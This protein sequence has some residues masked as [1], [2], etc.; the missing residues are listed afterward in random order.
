MKNIL[1]R[2]YKFLLPFNIRYFIWNYIQ[3]K[4]NEKIKINI[5]KYFSDDNPSTHNFIKEIEYLKKNKLSVLPYTEIHSVKNEIKIYSDNSNGLKYILFENKKI[6]FK[7]SMN[8]LEIKSYFNELLN[9]QHPNSPHRYL[10]NSFNINKS[11]IVADIGVAE[12]IFSISIID[13]V[14]FIYLFEPDPEW[15]EALAFTFAPWSSKIKIIPKFISDITSIDT[16]ALD[17]FFNEFNPVDFLKIDVDG[18][19]LKLLNGAKDLIKNSKKLKI[20]ICTYH[21]DNDAF[22]FSEIMKNNSFNISI[23]SGYMLFYFDKNFKPP[24]FRKGVLRASKSI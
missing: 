6:Y 24:Y 13:E 1:Y 20:A 17:D 19:E 16:L 12:G 15:L 22:M 8:F 21:N 5:L 2:I 10:S 9:E 18:A 7:R 11:S 3:Q 4:N 23:T 14:S